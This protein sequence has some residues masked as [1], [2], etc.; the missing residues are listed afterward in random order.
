[1]EKCKKNAFGYHNFLYKSIWSVESVQYG[2]YSCHI[3]YMFISKWLKRWN[4]PKTWTLK[5]KKKDLMHHMEHQILHWPHSCAG[6]VAVA[7]V[8]EGN[9][10]RRIWPD[11]AP[12]LCCTVLSHFHFRHAPG[13][14]LLI[15]CHGYNGKSGR[16]NCEVGFSGLKFDMTF[17]PVKRLFCKLVKLC[18][19]QEAHANDILYLWPRKLKNR[20][21]S[22]VIMK[23]INQEKLIE[24]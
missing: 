3:W 5:E 8:T 18:Q 15:H 10:V 17:S 11:P 24:W 9:H 16:L 1:M 7:C 2:K 12:R 21:L 22:L 13:P 19:G 20:G 4:C 6:S 23:V 14:W